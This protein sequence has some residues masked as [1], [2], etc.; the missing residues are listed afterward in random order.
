MNYGGESS[1]QCPGSI[2]LVDLWGEGTIYIYIYIYSSL[3]LSLIYIYIDVHI[4][5]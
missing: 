1:Q 5:I 2:N 4:Y 3:S